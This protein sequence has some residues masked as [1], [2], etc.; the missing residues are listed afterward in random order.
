M[1]LRKRSLIVKIVN[2]NFDDIKSREEKI[3]NFH[4][5]FFLKR[6]TFSFIIILIG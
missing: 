2:T 1:I 4:L 3:P 5:R 6:K